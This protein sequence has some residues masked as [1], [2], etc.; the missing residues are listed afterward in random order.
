MSALPHTIAWTAERRAQEL[1]GRRTELLRQ[2]PH[3][4]RAAQRLRHDICE[5]I[6]D[7]AIEF[8]SLHHDQDIATAHDLEGVFWSA[9]VTRVHR[10]REG[11]Y[12]LVRGRFT[13]VGDAALHTIASGEDPVAQLEAAHDRALAHEFALTLEPIERR[14]LQ[15]KYDTPGRAPAGYKVI[16][17][18]LD[19]PIGVVRS[20]ERSIEQ[21]IERFAA[22]YSAGRLCDM[23]AV[24]ITSLAAGTADERQAHIARAHVEHCAHCRPHFA[25]QLREFGSDAFAGKV[26]STIPML[27]TDDGQRRRLRGAWD[28]L[29]DTLTRPF[30]HDGTATA[31]QL[32]SSGAGR[33][34]GT[35][36]A[37][38]LAGACM[39][40]AGAIGVCATTFIAPALDELQ[41]TERRPLSSERKAQP[42]GEH[43][44]LPTRAEQKV[45]PTPTPSPK[46]RSSDSGRDLTGRTQGGTGQQDH[47]RTPASP[48]PANAAPGGESE[49]DP[50]YKPSSPATPAPVQAAPGSGEF[51]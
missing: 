31:A 25:Q 22:V 8:T 34:V 2:L 36:A 29:A 12:D 4:I 17:R 6:V 7:D 14:V 48:A 32:A 28:A 24:A 19:T 9:C 18:Q 11:R 50:T 42:V 27:A 21:K 43:H 23:R 3:E 46:R 33:G 13:S 41:R 47:E 45:V 44:R 16:A 5:L 49:F 37:L 15:A 20:A 38:K 10:A 1:V 39:A 26:A 40:S 51:F 35:I 30:V